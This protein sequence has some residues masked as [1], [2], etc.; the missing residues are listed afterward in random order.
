M[1]PSMKEPQQAWQALESGTSQAFPKS[2]L[3]WQPPVLKLVLGLISHGHE[4]HWQ[5]QVTAA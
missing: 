5:E 4:C 3:D 1:K 2:V